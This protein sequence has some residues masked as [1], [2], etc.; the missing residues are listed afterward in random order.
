MHRGRSRGNLVWRAELMMSI[1]ELMDGLVVA[2]ARES[3]WLV[4][5]AVL[6]VVLLG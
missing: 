4:V 1:I 6:D 5:M 2:V 3:D